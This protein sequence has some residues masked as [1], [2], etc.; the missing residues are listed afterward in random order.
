MMPHTYNHRHTLTIVVSLL[1]LC[2]G[3]LQS[4]TDEHQSTLPKNSLEKGAWALQFQIGNSFTL[5]A[6]QGATI[7]AKRH[8][9]ENSAIR[10]GTSISLAAS[11]GDYTGTTTQAD[12]IL[13]SN[14]GAASDDY[15]SI[16]VTA[17]YLYYPN[18]QALVN[19]FFGAGPL[20]QY[21][22]SHG[23]GNR[24]W[25]SSGGYETADSGTSDA[26]SWAI[27]ANAVAGVEWFATKSLSFHAEYGLSIQYIS[28][29]RTNSGTTK[30]D[31]PPAAPY[32][33]GFND[34]SFRKGWQ[35]D[36]TAVRFGLSVYF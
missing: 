33:R 27:G 36:G 24:L 30:I 2:S 28:T 20:I 18:P 8:Y 7:S 6:F 29:K 9:S 11:D 15:Q 5:R 35:F 21:S 32:Y 16:Q 13:G 25:S 31:S 22:R 12:T 4:Q 17:Q 1:I 3:N 14:S 19:V 26:K 34:E 10:L 23:N